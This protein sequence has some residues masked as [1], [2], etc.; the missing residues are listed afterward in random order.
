MTEWLHLHFS[1]SYIGEGNGNPLQRSCLENPRDGGA[2]W[3]VL[4]RVTQSRTWLKWL[5]SSSS[6]DHCF[7]NKVRCCI[8]APPRNSTWHISVIQEM[9]TVYDD[10]NDIW[11]TSVLLFPLSLIFNCFSSYLG[12]RYEL[13][14]YWPA[15]SFP[16]S[17]STLKLNILELTFHSRNME[18]STL[19]PPA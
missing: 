13:S 2:W 10:N 8:K 16:K 14:T 1:L 6:K 17:Y 9:V 18:M 7:E 3:T 11:F 4:Y 5:S 19:S 12:L 15:L